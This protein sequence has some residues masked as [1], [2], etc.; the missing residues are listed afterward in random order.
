MNT[1]FRLKVWKYVAIEV[2]YW[3]RRRFIF[4]GIFAFVGLNFYLTMIFNCILLMLSKD[5]LHYLHSNHFF[6]SWNT[7]N[8][9]KWKINILFI[10]KN[11]LKIQDQN[12]SHI[13]FP[14]FTT[15]FCIAFNLLSCDKWLSPN[16]FSIKQRFLFKLI[17][18]F[19]SVNNQFCFIMSHFHNFTSKVN[20]N[21]PYFWEERFY[22]TDFYGEKNK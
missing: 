1:F 21:N 19:S 22:P 16:H 2:L 12:F 17:F 8:L 6:H 20:P 11:F 4:Y 18:F 15:S 5:S 9:M 14:V 13:K 3:C 7:S 10:G